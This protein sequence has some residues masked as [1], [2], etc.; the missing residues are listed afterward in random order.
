MKPSRIV[1]KDMTWFCYREIRDSMFTD[2][3]TDH[4]FTM[5]SNDQ[6]LLPFLTQAREELLN[7]LFM[8]ML[9]HVVA[10]SEPNPLKSSLQT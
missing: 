6:N 8:F 9:K 5:L 7:I 10:F 4:Q 1:A 3:F 2:Q